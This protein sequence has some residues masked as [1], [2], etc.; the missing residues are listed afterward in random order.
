MAVELAN[1]Y[2]NI[3]PSTR[4]IAP[5]VKDA[6]KD[7]DPVAHKS[8]ESLGSKISGAMSKTLKLGAATAG[9]AVAGVFGT[10][11]AKGFSRMNAT[12][13]ATAKLKALGNDANDVAGIMDNALA[14]VKGTAFGI[15]EAAGT[16]STL[17]AAGIKPGQELQGVLD[18]VADTASIAGTSME[19][20]GLIFGKAAAKGKL[21]GEVVAQ[22]LERQIPVYDILSQKTGAA[23]ADIADMVSKGKIDFQTFSEAM[24]DYVGGGARVMADTFDG[25]LK[26]MFASMGRLGEAV[27]K[28]IYAAA[29]SLFKSVTTVFD[30]VTT[31]VK[32]AATVVGDLL[33]PAFVKVGTVIET[34]LAPY[35]AEVATHLGD[36]AV[37]LA[38]KAVDPQMWERVG[39]VFSSLKDTFAGMAPDLESL[40]GSFLTISKNVSVSTWEA[41][42]AVLNALA[43]LITSVLVPLVARTAELAEQHPDAVQ[44]IVT[45]FVGFKAV[46]GPVAAATGAIKALSGAISIL[47]GG[48]GVVKAL[49]SLGG[50]GAKLGKFAGVAGKFAGITGKVVELA[51]AVVLFNP[52]LTLIVAIT[53]ALTL[54]FTK[55]E[56]GRKLWGEFTQALSDGWQSFT[57][58]LSAGVDWA[59]QKW[60]EFTQVLSN[61]WQ[62]LTEAL[63]AGVDWAR[64]K[65]DE[66]TGW[67]SSTW[68]SI[69]DGFGLMVEAA[70][71]KWG[72]LT[73]WVA[74]KWQAA[75]DLVSAAWDGLQTGWQ[76]VA[77]FFVSAWQG[78]MDGI[79]NTW[80]KTVEVF[81]TITDTISDI[82]SLLFKGDFQ[83][84][85]DLFGLGDESSKLVDVLMTVHDT[86]VNIADGIRA[87]WDGCM[88]AMG[89]AMRFLGDV[90]SAVIDAIVA[91]FN[92]FRDVVGAVIEAVKGYFQQFATKVQS[93]SQDAIR[94]VGEIP[95]KIKGFFSGAGSWLVDAGRQMIQGLISGI[96]SMAGSVGNAVKSVIPHPLGGLVGLSGGGLAG[97]ARGGVLPDIPGIP[98]S[99]RDPILGVDRGGVPVARV[100]PGEFIVNRD[101]TAKNLPLLRAINGGKLNPAQGDLGLPRYAN[102][103]VVSA[104][105]LLQF[106]AGQNVDGKQAPGPLEGYPYTWGGGLLSNWGDCS[107]AMSGL[108][109]FTVGMALA[110][111][112]F[113]TMNEGQVLSSMG[114]SRGTSSGKSAF[115]IGFFNGGPYGGHTAGTIYDENGKATNVEMGGGRG[116]G[117]I[118]GRAAGSRDNQF[119][120]RYYIN[121]LGGAGSALED[122]QIVSTSVD[123]MT[124]AS[125]KQS[126]QYQIDWGTASNLA[127]EWDKR[128][129]KNKQLRRF[130]AGVFDT[131]GIMPHGMAAVNLSGKPERVLDPRTTAAFERVADELPS[132]ADAMN[133]FAST[134]WSTVGE[135]IAAAW[136]GEDFGYGELASLVGD[137]WGQK[138]VDNLS[139][140]G[141]Q[142]RDMQ[143]GANMRAYLSSM[144]AMETVGLADQVGQLVGL[145]DIN[146]LFG[147]VAKSYEGLQDAAVAQVDAADAVTQAEK[148]LADARKDYADRLAES[149]A[150]PEVSKKT[151]RRI[152]DSERKLAE[153]RK[154]GDPKKIAD[155]ERNLA[156]VREDAQDELQKSGAKN[157]D[158]LVKSAEAVSQAESDLAKAQGVVQLAA[159]AT[160]QAQIAMALEVVETVEKVVEWVSQ[161]V[162]DVFAGVVSAWSAISGMFGA[163]AEFQKIVR[164]LR[165]DVTRLAL[166]QALAQIE[167]AAAYRNVRMVA[168]DGVRAQLEG[169]VSVARAQAEF[170]ASL[171]ADM[172]AAMA[173]YEGLSVEFDRFRHNAFT[174]FDEITAASVAWSDRTWALWWELQ[175]AQT[176]R[177]IL[178]KQAQ[179]DLLEAQYKSTLAALDLAAVTRDLDKATQKLALA[180]SQ[181]FGMDE[182]GATVGQRWANLQTEKAQLKA[183]NA[184]VKT[185]LNPINWFTTMPAATARMKQIDAELR[186]LEARP[187]FQMEAATR[188]NVSRSVNKAGV[189]G[190]FG[191]GDQVDLMM[192]NTA[193]DAARAL[194]RMKFENELI[195]LK[196]EQADFRSKIER[197]QAELDYRRDSDP[198]ELA[199]K[200]LESE[201]A[202]QKTYAEMYRTDNQGVKDALLALAKHQEDTARNIEVMSRQRAEDVPPVALYGSSASM[203]DVQA[204]LEAL[205]HRVDRVENPPA[206][207]ALVAASRR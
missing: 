113:A 40:G 199:L 108:A 135:E 184:N 173:D 19:D 16:A 55:T 116:N 13:N 59:Q 169:I 164:G 18:A 123:G 154:S 27:E 72:E 183:N 130:T 17:V 102:G 65:W 119:T 191:A 48:G 195:D 76:A 96:K 193:G 133:R 82:F 168:M 103:G 77:D 110:G 87:V 15:G 60:S 62:A 124:V 112:K 4:D 89:N 172:R 152:E 139:F 182:V 29:P 114:F 115:E 192:K 188:R 128:N 147:G 68:Q 64:E 143:D 14:S 145:K 52:W 160:G 25:S 156:R 47:K 186:E 109:A 118:G 21:D 163:V 32:P 198:L 57:E 205:G 138:I 24:T 54:F 42:T 10:S 11:L 177:L 137:E 93:S 132:V 63:G 202:A 158:E 2:I 33:A 136:N 9:T 91:G 88:E 174:T 134:D 206:S 6:L 166:D 121:L 151:A 181:A 61:G 70:K 86:V 190:F 200:A 180:T 37:R 203:D 170:D 101:A 157:A 46:Q 144:S 5:A 50:I 66:F 162:Q 80:D 189:M 12:S 194:D 155:A 71:A 122:G 120:D 201:Q 74:E 171:R 58:A 142:V 99:V 107:G 159:E 104:R 105:K 204:M 28:P 97:F 73:D 56:T 187:E 38:T 150:D 148:N 43:P 8:G 140:I 83:G 146:N 79:A 75:Q 111:R 127:S 129:H 207:A 81:H 153:A 49:S 94:A 44:A 3:I 167:L 126:K 100:E 78:A 7:L 117:Q 178:E 26:N 67:L 161:K 92:T 22:L 84:N 20:M 34:K 35:A 95:G 196:S 197:S 175:A 125:G 36:L 51:K 23:S 69:Q 149:G 131:G 185:W 41:L 30:Q 85:S 39:D 141:Y 165:E 53:G 1:A 106:A 176:G 98:R 90:I 31:A 45:A 179:A